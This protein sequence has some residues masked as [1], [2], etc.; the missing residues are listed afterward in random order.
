VKDWQRLMWCCGSEHLLT[1][2]SPEHFVNN[3]GADR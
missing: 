2:H 1:I 3:T